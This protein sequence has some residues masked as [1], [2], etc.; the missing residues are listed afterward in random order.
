MKYW[1][2]TTRPFHWKITRIW[3]L[4]TD[5]CF[6]SFAIFEVGRLFWE[7]HILF[8]H[9]FVFLHRKTAEYIKSLWNGLKVNF[10]SVKFVFICS[11][12]ISYFSFI[13]H[14]VF[15]VTNW[16]KD[17]AYYDLKKKQKTKNKKVSNYKSWSMR[18]FLSWCIQ[19][20]LLNWLKLSV[21][22]I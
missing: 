20:N 10:L 18:F 8:L 15:K 6:Y 1:L 21:F 3:C 4:R 19:R 14:T 7:S 5:K 11:K 12:Q 17:I 2:M 22:P 13:V 16:S 9:C